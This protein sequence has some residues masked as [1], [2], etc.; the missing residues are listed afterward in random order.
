MAYTIIHG[1]AGG[2]RHALLLRLAARGSHR[3]NESFSLSNYFLSIAHF[4]RIAFVVGDKADLLCTLQQPAHFLGNW[5]V[6]DK[7][8]TEALISPLCVLPMSGLTGEPEA[9][10]AARAA[11]YIA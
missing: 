5:P 1:H 7:V 11:S 10:N 2:D 8:L 4:Y 9:S 6:L 3:G